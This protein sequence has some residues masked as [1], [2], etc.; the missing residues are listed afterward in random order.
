MN[1]LTKLLLPKVA[2]PIGAVLLMLLAG[3]GITTY[4]QA[5][6]IESLSVSLGAKKSELVVWKAAAA[7]YKVANDLSSDIIKR[8][9][10]SIKALKEKA[11]ASRAAYYQRLQA[12]TIV[13]S[14]LRQSAESILKLDAGTTDELDLC[15]AAR[16]L[17][18]KEL[19]DA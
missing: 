6:R 13:A 7:S 14:S 15:R 17:L 12:S 19:T 5:Q 16:D 9:T 1:I 8:Q 10:V 11:D 18:E 2:G 4:V 3:L